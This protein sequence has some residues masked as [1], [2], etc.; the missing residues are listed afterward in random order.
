M[1]TIGILGMMITSSGDLEEGNDIKLI[2]NELKYELECLSEFEKVH[3][4]HT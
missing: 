1:N 3:L 2:I 4:S